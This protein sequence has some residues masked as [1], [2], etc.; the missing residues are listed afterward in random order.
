M[1]GNEIGKEGWSAERLEERR[2]RFEKLKKTKAKRNEMLRVEANYG[3]RV[4]DLEQFRFR[5]GSNL[6]GDD[7]LLIPEMKKLAFYFCTTRPLIIRT[8][9]V[10]S[11]SMLPEPV[12]DAV[13]ALAFFNTK[14]FHRSPYRLNQVV[15]HQTTLIDA[16]IWKHV[17]FMAT[18]EYGTSFHSLFFA[19]ISGSGAVTFCC[20][21]DENTCVG[22]CQFCGDE[23]RHPNDGGFLHGY[24]PSQTQGGS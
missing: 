16:T 10:L 5:Y 17:N 14:F 21:L 2:L 8:K 3:F 7:F 23:I 4:E 15:G 24:A 1:M 12:D 11:S 6:F 22:G 9:E 20:T 13:T 18:R 19:E